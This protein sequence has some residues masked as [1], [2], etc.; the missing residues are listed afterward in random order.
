MITKALESVCSQT[1]RPI[2]LIVA[3]DGSTDNMGAVLEAWRED[4]PRDNDIQIHLVTQDNAGA[5]L[6]KH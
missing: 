2:E 1:Y 5:P 4:L 3:D 6:E